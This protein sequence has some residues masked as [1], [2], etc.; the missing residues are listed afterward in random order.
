VGTEWARHPPRS[1]LKN[2][3][4]QYCNL[5]LS[6]ESGSIPLQISSPVLVV[7][8]EEW[9]LGGL[10]ERFAWHWDPHVQL[11]WAARS[12]KIA[13]GGQRRYHQRIPLDPSPAEPPRFHGVEVQPAREAG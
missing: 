11:D 5:D 3:V 8:W 4:I 1:T 13:E 2:E 7:S 10:W 6:G 12:V 9:S